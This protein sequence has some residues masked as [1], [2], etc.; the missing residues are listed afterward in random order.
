MNDEIDDF[1]DE[2][3]NDEEEELQTFE[4][5]VTETYEK[6]YTVEATC[7]EDAIDMA[8]ELASEDMELACPENMVNRESC[9]D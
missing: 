9:L 1:D 4:V 7:M 8:D 2:E 6:V 3:L 5:R